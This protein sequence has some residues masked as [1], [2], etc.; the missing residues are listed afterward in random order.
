MRKNT[1]RSA[2]L[3]GVAAVAIG[4]G[5]AAW[6]AGWGVD[7][8]GTA[9]ATASTIKNLSM[10]SIIS[11]K[12][13]PGLSTTMSSAVSN[14]NDFKVQLT[15]SVTPKIITVTPAGAEADTCKTGLAAPGILNTNFPGTP[16]IPAGAKN[17][18]L[19]STVTIGENLPK[20]C[21]GKTIKIDYGFTGVSA[22]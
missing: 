12:I 3:A 22:A 1:K 2:V 6:A 17:L 5:A 13:Y 10:T 19:T 11:A 7:G 14:E 21:A 9:E 16:V 20:A 8:D 4:G 18:K 15:G